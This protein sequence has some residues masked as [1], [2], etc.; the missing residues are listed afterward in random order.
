MSSD[1]R[2]QGLPGPVADAVRVA[3]GRPHV[4]L[5]SDFDGTLAPFRDDPMSVAPDPAGVAS[6]REAAGM[7][8]VHVALVSGRDLAVLQ[9]LSG[10]GDDER[11]IF[12][13]THG[14]QTSLEVGSG[15]LSEAQRD[16]LARLDAG[17]QRVVA[18]HP[19]ARLERK[20]AAVVLH[21]RGMPE[22]ENGAAL[23]A[24]AAVAAAHPGCHPLRGKNVQEIGVHAADKGTALV[25]LARHVRAD[26]VVYLG[27]DVTDERAFT[28]LRPAD[29]DLTIKVGE[30]ETAAG[31]RVPGIPSAV[32]CLELFVATRR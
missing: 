11:V 13:G 23:D 27:D 9:E 29:G 24:A 6:L 10:M 7:P 21:T 15:A 1:S 14:A 20:P 2:V 4:L 17:L 12:I 19:G 32:A 25:N 8:G 5:A 18:A 16:L 22:P 31:W 26:I 3:A 28:A 30:G